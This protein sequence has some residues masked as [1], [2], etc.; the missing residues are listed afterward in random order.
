MKLRTY[1]LTALFFTASSYAMAEHRPNLLST[2]VENVRLTPGSAYYHAQQMDIRYL[3]ALDPDRL[4]APYMKGAGLTPK[5][6]NYSNWEN[7][8]LDGHIGGHY[9]SALSY[10]Y[11]ATGN[12][13]ILSRL[14]YMVSELGRAQAAKGNGYLCG[15]PLGEELWQNIKRG[16][17]RAQG[18]SLNKAWVPL[19]NI[20]KIYA[21]LRDAWLI[22]HQEEAR[23]ILIR[24]TDWM[25]DITSALTDEQVQTMLISEHGGL[26]ETFADV[27][28]ITG[29]ERYLTMARRFSHRAILDPMLR[30]ENKLDGIHANTQIPK[31]VGFKRIA[32]ITG[33][34]DWNRAAAWFWQDVT[35]RRSVSIGGNSVRE[36]FHPA[37]DFT[38][39]RESEQGPETCNTYNMLRLSKMLWL[40]SGDSKYMDF[41]ERALQNHILSS[42]DP[43][44]GGFVYFTPM[45]SGHYRVYSQP[46]TSMWCCVGSGME[47]H[48]RYGEYIYA[49]D[50]SEKSLYVNLFIPSTVK[51]SGCSIEQQTRFPEEEGT[52]FVI[53]EGS[54]QKYRLHIRIP[55]WASPSEI[56]ATLNGQPAKCQSE[57]GYLTIS[58]QWQQG[59]SLHITLPMHLRA[60]QMA[61][62]S[63]YYSFLYGPVVLA[64]Q[65]GHDRQ[66]GLFAD[67]SRGGHIAAGPKLPLTSMPVIVEDNPKDL[68]AHITPVADKALTFSLKANENQI[69]VPFYKLY[70]C[71]YMVYWP[72]YTSAER[73]KML[74]EQTRSEQEQL[75]LDKRTSDIVI[76]GEQQPESDHF[77]QM[78]KSRTGT[79]DN[80]HWRVADKGGSFGYTMKNS[81]SST[82]RIAYMPSA[83]AD[84]RVM[85]DGKQIGV[86]PASASKERVIAELPLPKTDSEKVTVTFQAD[87][88]KRTPMV[89]EIRIIR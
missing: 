52:S 14:R 39:M 18:F 51:W 66:D 82:L 32:D 80:G 89:Y 61:D 44:Q 87:T 58:R 48:A 60:E 28:A 26:N 43:V 47:N 42:I 75:A 83:N 3:L 27:Y 81:P 33:D 21:G 56:S 41:V 22:A 40:S 62:G 11:A 46:Q 2:P 57:N 10:M 54:K 37:T 8:G 1:I 16:E 49:S 70:E 50:T 29:D 45:R 86:V 7:T 69:L 17:I 88:Q 71:R 13:E 19:Y 73:E 24:L 63:P 78:D 77:V 4:L 76:C 20:H 6:E 55:A 23:N 79:D 65:T 35:T 31:V 64:A 53:R 12:E 36:H 30:A 34:S 9:L 68:L 84:M 67:D 38:P 72:V 25:Y 74:T 59:D 5:A 85:I 15:D